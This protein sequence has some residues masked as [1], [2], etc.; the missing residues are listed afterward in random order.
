MGRTF[1]RFCGLMVQLLQ[2]LRIRGTNWS[3]KLLKVIKGPVSKHLPIG[4]KTLGFSFSAK[5]L[6]NFNDFVQKLNDY[7]PIVLVVGAFAHGKIE[8]SYMDESISIS[9]YPLSAAYCLN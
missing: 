2:R 4:C 6:V 3:G 9:Q 7:K 8:A 5:L 1:G